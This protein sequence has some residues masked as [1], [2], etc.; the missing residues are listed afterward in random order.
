MKK[1][2]YYSNDELMRIQA[3]ELEI[4]KKF[5]EIC[6]RYSLRY[7]LDSGTLLGAVRHGGFIPWD[8]DVDVGMPRT[9]Y[10]R[11]LEIAQTELGDE[12]FLQNRKSDPKCPFLF[13]KI[14]KNGTLFLEW[15]KRNIKMHHGIF[16][17]VFPYDILPDHGRDAY[18]DKCKKLYRRFI[19]GAI[20]D[21]VSQ[22]ELKIE[23]IA[24][25]TARRSTYRFTKVKNALSKNMTADVMD[26]LFA[27]YKAQK[28]AA[29]TCHFYSKKIIFEEQQM[30]PAKEIK[31]E[32]ALFYCPACSDEI[33]TNIY[34]DFMKLPPEDKRHGHR[35]AKISFQ[36]K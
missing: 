33:L 31:F 14:R 22:P 13:S 4:L 3:I 36:E 6:K 30:F 18:I 29:Y 21:V 7:V 15:N 35:P 25:E 12:Y 8:D 24:K 28:A 10:E 27:K 32:D 1:K 5:A 23:W 17:D 9:D 20:P 2:E 19:N 11:F 26:N 34:G 16:I